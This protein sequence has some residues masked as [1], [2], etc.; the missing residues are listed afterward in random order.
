MFAGET[1][2]YSAIIFL[3]Y[4]AAFAAYNLGII[5]RQIAVNRT[6]PNRLLDQLLLGIPIS[7]IVVTP[8]IPLLN[9]GDI[10]CTLVTIGIIIEHGML[11]NETAASHLR[12]LLGKTDFNCD[13]A[14]DRLA[15]ST[16][17]VS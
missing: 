15:K 14:I 16:S 11:V 7:L 17:T 10:K 2:N 3:I 9:A 5:I 4:V 1:E 8:L 13:S 6:T 12:Q